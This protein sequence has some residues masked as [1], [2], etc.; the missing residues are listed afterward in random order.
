MIG[1]Y[2]ITNRLN[3]KA[4]VGQSVHIERRW[5][6]HMRPSTDSLISRAIKEH[7]KENFDFQVVCECLEEDLNSLEEYY[8]KKYNTVVPNGYN[9]L[10]SDGSIRTHFTL[11]M[12]D[13]LSVIISEIKDTD[14]PFSVIG[15]KHNLSR[16]TIIRIN[17]GDVHKHPEYKYPLRETKFNIKGETPRCLICGSVR[18]S[19]AELCSACARRNSRKIVERPNATTLAELLM[20]NSFEDVGAQYGLNPETI[21]KWCRQCGIPTSRRRIKELYNSKGV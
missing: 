18:S 19:G 3:G 12:P 6:E 1:I 5:G 4:Y 8:I 13:E 15:R 16:R 17:K 7:G 2:K 9:V 14:T 21:R 20:K 11:Y 10:R